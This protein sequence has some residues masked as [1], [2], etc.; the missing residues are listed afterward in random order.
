[1]RKSFVALA[2]AVVGL[3][4]AAS[5]ADA[6]FTLQIRV[7]SYNAAGVQTAQDTSPV[8]GPFATPP[9]VGSIALTSTVGNFN[10][11]L[12]NNIS[13]ENFLN[14]GVT[15][16]SLT[17]NITYSGPVDN[18]TTAASESDR[19]VV[20]FIG[21]GYVTPPAGLAQVVSNASPSVGTLSASSVTFVSGVDNSP[22]GLPGAVGD[23]SGLVAAS[24][25]T[26][27]GAMGPASSVLS[28]NPAVSSNFALNNPFS[29]YQVLT[30]DRFTNTGN[31]SL[32]AGSV[33]GAPAPGGVV[34]ALTALP[35]L[36]VFGWLRRR[37]AAKTA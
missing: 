7:T 24:I 29:F 25:T 30:F 15:S 16:H 33:V 3:L 4:N 10:V 2:L 21:E 35:A 13:N 32:S 37:K 17:T 23:T 18:T 12:T 34:L 36:G 5:A 11:V 20:E 8:T 31:G 27:T 19:L 1:M 9:G 22:L 26:Q 14:S 28:P 6:A